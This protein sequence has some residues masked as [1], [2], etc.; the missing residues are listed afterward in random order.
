MSDV[1]EG[2]IGQREFARREG[3]DEKQVRRGVESGRLAAVKEGGKVFLNPADIGSG[4]RRPRVDSTGA[5]AGADTA[6]RSAAAKARAGRGGTGQGS[7]DAPELNSA[8]GSQ[9]KQ[10]VVRKED[11]T[12]RLRELEFRHKAGEL[13]DL[14]VAR[15]VLFDEARRARDAWLNWPSRFAAL[16]AADLNVEADR[17]AEVLTTYVHKQ[18]AALG[19]P[20]GDFG[21][22]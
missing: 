2:W 21:Q 22:G 7:A 16:I 11:F 14:A 8:V 5:D 20:G 9:L 19:E 3:C 1:P 15:R 10:A 12:G 18:L 4:W 17:A 6:V 13:I